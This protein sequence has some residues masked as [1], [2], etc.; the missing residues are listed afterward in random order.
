MRFFKHVLI[1]IGICLV[2]FGVIL[3]HLL[4]GMPVPPEIWIFSTTRETGSGFHLI[5][6]LNGTAL[7][8]VNPIQLFLLSFIP[9]NYVMLFRV[10]PAIEA[11]ILAASVYGFVSSIKDFKTGFLAAVL[12]VTSYGFFAVFE[13]FDLSAFPITMSVC[14]YLLFSATYLK[15]G[16]GAG[17]IFSYILAGL[18]VISGGISYLVFFV[19]SSVALILLD[20]APERL[21]KIKPGWFLAIAIT[22]ITA[23][24]ITFR[25]TGGSGYVSGILFAGHRE[26]FF[27]SLWDMIKFNLPW[28][29]LLI[30]AWIKSDSP[31]AWASWRSMLPAKIAITVAFLMTW[32]IKTDT[33]QFAFIAVPFACILSGAWIS[34]GIEKEKGMLASLPVLL[35]GIIIIAASL[36]YF[37]SGA[38]TDREVSVV[39]LL[40][41]GVLVLTFVLMLLTVKRKSYTES[42][43]L[44][45]IAAVVFSFFAITHGAHR[46]T[47]APAKFFSSFVSAA[48]VVVYENDL[49]T[50]GYLSYSGRKA[51]VVKKDFVPFGA[52]VLLAL[53]SCNIKKELKRLNKIANASLVSSS[54]D[55]GNYAV[56]VLKPLQ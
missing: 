53:Q 21:L 52:E 25:I 9:D 37:V 48:P 40:V 22:L 26:G 10:I 6:I 19:L 39:E 43:L 54:N 47:D 7:N 18:A 1:L 32:L 30:P 15:N 27:L 17:Y 50:R 33:P 56:V 36:V 13:H 29:F 28:I 12:S 31:D 41:F 42:V 51:F 11:A 4:T 24:S 44:G 20:L 8:G 14:A 34:N 23:F 45:I 38:I 46:H 49:T 16:K 3:P 2:G 55:G 35:S 5:P